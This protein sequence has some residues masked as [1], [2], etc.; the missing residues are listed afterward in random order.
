MK[1]FIAYYRVSTKQQGVSGLGLDSQKSIVNNYIGSN[2]LIAEFKETESGK[3]NNRPELLKAIELCKTT[4]ATLVIAKL[5]RLSRNAQFIFSLKDSSIDFIACDI[6]EANTLTIGIMA[7]L[8]QQEREL[9]SERTKSALLALKQR[10]V[11]LGTPAN[12]TDYSRAKA[13]TSIKQKALDNANNVKAIAMITALSNQNL[14]LRQIAEKL[15]NSGFKT[16][17]G[18]EFQATSVMRLQAQI[19]AV[20]N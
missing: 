11:K 15:N 5:D 20:S 6:P 16:S 3:N 12:L 13:K 1:Q 7:L 17:T 2:E 4:G 10:G 18:K 14:S 19:K 9:I 8:A